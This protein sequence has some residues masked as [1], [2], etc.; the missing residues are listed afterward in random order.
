[1]HHYYYCIHTYFYK[2]YLY[3][4]ILYIS[5]FLELNRS[6]FKTTVFYN[7]P[8]E[9]SFQYCNNVHIY[10]FLC[11][12]CVNCSGRSQLHLCMSVLLF[13]LHHPYLWTLCTHDSLT[14]RQHP[15][16]F[17][18]PS[19]TKWNLSLNV[20]LFD[21]ILSSGM[22]SNQIIFLCTSSSM[23]HLLKIPPHAHTQLFGLDTHMLS[24][25]ALH[26][27]TSKLFEVDRQK[28]DHL[29]N[30]KIT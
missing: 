22:S 12:A 4:D 3:A 5:F 25:H 30:Y 6:S 16:S 23:T 28:N 10:I 9:Y 14:L 26:A 18:I 15:N 20:L 8:A 24:M 29:S 11:N 21:H 2:I 1:M 19:K 13:S 7:I 17:C 27:P